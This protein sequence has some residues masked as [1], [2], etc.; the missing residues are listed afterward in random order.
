MIYLWSDLHYYFARNS[1]L[2]RQRSDHI[3][4]NYA[5]G[6]DSD[7]QSYLHD[8]VLDSRGQAFNFKNLLDQLG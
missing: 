3:N 4:P 6:D 7:Y 2:S 1:K 5:V 8:L